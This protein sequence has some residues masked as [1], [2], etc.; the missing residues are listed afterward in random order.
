[1]YG[2][3]HPLRNRL[4][5]P[6]RRFVHCGAAIGLALLTG[7]SLARAQIWVANEAVAPRAGAV[8]MQPSG[9]LVV[10]QEPVIAPPSGVLL[11]QP[12]QTVQ[13]VPVQTVE[14]VQTAQPANAPRQRVSGMQVARSRSGDQVRT[15]R[16]TTIHEGVAAVSPAPAQVVGAPAVV[17]AYARLYD[18]VAPG[19][20][21]PPGAALPAMVVTQPLVGTAVVAPPAYHYVYEPDRILVIDSNTGIA[22]QAIAR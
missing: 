5:F 13:T 16:T 20:F 11:M 4:E 10:A 19:P 8:I 1:M 14:T 21:A 2:S 18:F 12:V 22:V 6:M 17:P 15:T 9:S 3:H 7:T